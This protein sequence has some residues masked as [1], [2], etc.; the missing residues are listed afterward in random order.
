[1][2]EKG[3]ERMRGRVFNEKKRDLEGF[4]TLNFFDIEN[5]ILYN[6]ILVKRLILECSITKKGE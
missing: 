4:Q 2:K 3:S 6:N 1:M 5:V